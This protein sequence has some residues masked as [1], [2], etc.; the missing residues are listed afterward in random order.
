MIIISEKCFQ[1]NTLTVKMQNVNLK[2]YRFAVAR[3]ANKLGFGRTWRATV[4]LMFR[5]IHSQNNSN[6]CVRAFKK[7]VFESRLII[8]MRVQ[9]RTI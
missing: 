5:K 1:R 6:E 2:R 8:Q 9:I 4:L 3:G 7:C